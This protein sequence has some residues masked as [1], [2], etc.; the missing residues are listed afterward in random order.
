MRPKSVNAYWC[1]NVMRL[2]SS[3][4]PGRC[5]RHCQHDDTVTVGPVMAFVGTKPPRRGQRVMPDKR[6]MVGQEQEEQVAVA[7]KHIVGAGGWVV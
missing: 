3:M 6:Y 2:T 4:A 5:G 1:Q 7:P